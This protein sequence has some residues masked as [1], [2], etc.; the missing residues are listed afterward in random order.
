MYRILTNKCFVANRE[1]G[2]RAENLD[3]IH[4]KYITHVNDASY[5]YATDDPEEFLGLCGDEVN[6][7][8]KKL[9]TMERSCLMLKTMEKF[10]YKEIAAILEI[11]FG[12][13]MTHL[14]RGRAKL[15]KELMDYAY[16]CGHIKKEKDVIEFKTNERSIG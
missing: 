14:S 1:I 15:R 11:P 2:R 6:I 12:T 10:S 4:E 7:A 8:M 3:D 9:S 5:R 16:K 13:V